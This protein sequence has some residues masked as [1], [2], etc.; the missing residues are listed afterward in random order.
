MSLEN[1]KY[2]R[3]ESNESQVTGQLSCRVCTTHSLLLAHS[4]LLPPCCSCTLSPAAP[5]HSPRLLPAAGSGVVGAVFG[6]L[7]RN[8]QSGFNL[9]GPAWSNVLNYSLKSREK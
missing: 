3:A 4:L 6:P 8:P 9:I 5:A 7:Y 2:W 1:S